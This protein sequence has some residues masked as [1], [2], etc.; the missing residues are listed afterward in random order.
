MNN[1]KTI[2]MF[3]DQLEYIDNEDLEQKIAKKLL[4][5]F[6]LLTYIM[7][8]TSYYDAVEN[9]IQIYF[10]I[11]DFVFLISAPLTYF[12]YLI[13]EHVSNVYHSSVKGISLEKFK[14]MKEEESKKKERKEEDFKKKKQKEK[15]K[16][17][18]QEDEADEQ[19]VYSNRVTRK[20]K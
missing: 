3:D 11:K 17:D 12:L 13:F 10:L 15:K 2:L 6:S 20:K 7:F 14:E 1:Q 8:Q 16:D 19:S 9:K 5:S 18:E 4:K